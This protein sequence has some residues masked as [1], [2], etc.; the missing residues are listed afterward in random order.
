[1]S[2]V[3]PQPRAWLA[4]VVALCV[5]LA[6]IRESPHLADE[7]WEDE[8]ATLLLFAADGVGH[9]F[10]DYRLPNNH[11]LFSA[12]LSLWW[13]R[14]DSVFHA[15][16]LPAL[17]WLASTALL[18]VIGR[19]SLGW[20][21]AALG[22]A[23]W[24]GSALV[25]AFQLGLRGYAFS[26]PFTL[27]LFAACQQFIVAGRREAAL[28]V[29]GAGVASIAILPTNAMVVAVCV[30]WALLRDYIERGVWRPAAALRAAIAAGMSLLGVLI[31]LPHRAEVQQ[32]MHN[33]FSHWSTSD[34]L[35]HW[36]LASSAPYWPLLPV[37]LAG[38]WAA[39]R[40]EPV[41]T[42]YARHAALALAV[43]LLV[44][45]VLAV[46]LSPTPLVPRALVPLLPLWCLALG[47]LLAAAVSYLAARLRQPL[48]PS[49]AV[50]AAF[51][52]A[53]GQLVPA[54][55]GIAWRFPS[56]DDLCHQFYRHDYRPDTL[57]RAID[58]RFAGQTVL[59][60]P[61][62]LWPLA[63]AQWNNRLRHIVAL[64][65]G[66]WP[67]G[68]AAPLPRLLISESLDGGHALLARVTHAQPREMV[69]VLDSGVLKLYAL[70]WQ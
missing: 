63:F 60:D 18:L 50:V 1:M 59:V 7:V 36:L 31:Y 29:L 67:R 15:R 46:A 37:L 10:S 55:A 40:A 57:A 65:V 41:A 44:V 42:R 32:H 43:S 25:A 39:A 61:H 68:V 62:T 5:L 69:Q 54:C 24:S 52:F 64:D 11:M 34:I 58:A 48:M 8:A 17:M 35:S 45:I 26:W 30:C 3:A 53:L 21:A 6:I 33:G 47:G 19:R 23:L 16:L 14:G 9:A 49:L 27:L 13:A 22:A 70:R 2:T 20:P 38:V 12:T 51:C 28:L 66:Q 56:G 4:W